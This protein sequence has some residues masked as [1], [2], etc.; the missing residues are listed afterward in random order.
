MKNN[1][2]ERDMQKHDSDM[3]TR[4]NNMEKNMNELTKSIND[5]IQINTNIQKNIDSKTDQ[6]IYQ[7]NEKFEI[8]NNKLNIIGRC[9]ESV[10]MISA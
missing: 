10:V 1:R 9:D 4:M 5:I 2:V 7:L 3:V 8:L 6:A